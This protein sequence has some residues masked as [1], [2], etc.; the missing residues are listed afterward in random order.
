[1][2]NSAQ[3]SAQ[4]LYILLLTSL[5][6]LSARYSTASLNPD[7]V[8]VVVEIDGMNY[9]Q[10]ESVRS[11][12]QFVMENINKVSSD[13]PATMDLSRFFVT[14]ASLYL[15]AKNMSSSRLGTRDVH[16]IKQ[17]QNGKELSRYILVG[18]QP[19]SWSIEKVDSTLGGFYERIGLAV[20]QISIQ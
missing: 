15:W 20:Q 9:G 5:V 4:F 10:L 1:M 3:T 16:L 12:D 6:I 8:S 19:T 14:D 17:N 2:K 11:V 7:I 13:N 18:C